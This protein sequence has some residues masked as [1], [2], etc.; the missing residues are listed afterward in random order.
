M[1]RIGGWA[2]ILDLNQDGKDWRMGQDFG[3]EP[4]WK[5]LEDGPRFW[6]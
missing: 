3:F 5:G 1:E 6:I 4:G 2:K